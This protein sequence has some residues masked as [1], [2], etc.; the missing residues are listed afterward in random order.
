MEWFES[1]GETKEWLEQHRTHKGQ[2][3]GIRIAGD[4]L[5]PTEDTGDFFMLFPENR[6][7]VPDER[8]VFVRTTLERKIEILQMFEKRTITPSET[9]LAQRKIHYLQ[10]WLK[11]LNQQIRKGQ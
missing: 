9:E 11:V 2:D 5:P 1:F 6:Y 3:I 8:F 10:N 4:I 7:P